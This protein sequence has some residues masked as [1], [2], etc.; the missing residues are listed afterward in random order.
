MCEM[1]NG[2]TAAC[3]QCPPQHGACAQMAPSAPSAPALSRWACG[4]QHGLLLCTHTT[5]V[6][7]LHDAG[8]QLVGG[9]L[10]VLAATTAQQNQG[11]LA[12][13]VAVQI[14]QLTRACSTETSTVMDVE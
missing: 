11:N 14:T 3:R 6:C 10:Q 7:R 9:G 4:G 2:C 12:A 1:L 13:P 8:W 5:K